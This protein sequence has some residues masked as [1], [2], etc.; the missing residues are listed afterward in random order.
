MRG[1]GSWLRR[2]WTG[3]LGASACLLLGAAGHTGAG[4]TL[5][6]PVALA[7]IFL[8]LVVLCGTLSTVRRRHPGKTVLALVVAQAA[9]HPVFHLL[10]AAPAAP[11]GP[12]P[13]RVT[14][15][16][17]V[18]PHPAGYPA[19][20]D[21]HLTHFGMPLA[22][23]L[24]ALGGVLTLFHCDRVLARLAV[25]LRRPVRPPATVT[26]VPSRSVRQWVVGAAPPA[27]LF[28]VLLARLRPRRGP[29]V[30]AS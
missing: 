3:L 6:G 1:P 17:A 26:V 22:H 14:G 23:A 4:G 8:V 15:P 28:G 19:G 13:G 16:H 24:A 21:G 10:S 18:G 25:L 7:G 30:T 9:L 5:P 27:P 12:A 11:A 2:P 29:P 20:A